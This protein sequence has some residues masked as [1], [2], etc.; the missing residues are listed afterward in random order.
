MRDA[1]QIEEGELIWMIEPDASN[2]DD[3][4]KSMSSLAK[5]WFRA[6]GGGVADTVFANEDFDT[7]LG[8]GIELV[9]RHKRDW[10][11]NGAEEQLANGLSDYTTHVVI[12][13][14]VDAD[15]V[16]EFA[17]V[18]TTQLALHRQP[19]IRD[20]DGTIP[21]LGV[22]SK[23]P[24][25]AS[26][27]FALDEGDPKTGDLPEGME[28]EGNFVRVTES[29]RYPRALG[30]K[31]SEEG[32]DDDLDGPQ[33]VS[34]IP[35]RL[36]VP[37]DKARWFQWARYAR[38]W[39]VDDVND[40]V[41]DPNSPM[42]DD[43]E[44]AVELDWEDGEPISSRLW[45]PERAAARFV[46]A[47]GR[48]TRSWAKPWAVRLGTMPNLHVS[49][50]YPQTVDG[51][52]DYPPMAF[53]VH[54]QS[55]G[56]R[57]L[58]NRT[59]EWEGNAF[60]VGPPLGGGEYLGLTMS[61]DPL[62][63]SDNLPPLSAASPDYRSVS[64]DNPPMR[65]DRRWAEQKAS[66]AP[67][68]ADPSDDAAYWSSRWVV[69]TLVDGERDVRVL[70]TGDPEQ[71][72]NLPYSNILFDADPANDY[73]VA[74][75][76]NDA[77]QFIADFGAGWISTNSSLPTTSGVASEY[78][79]TYA[80]LLRYRHGH[81]YHV[82]WDPDGLGRVDVD[83]DGFYADDNQLESPYSDLNP[84]PYAWA[85]RNTRLPWNW[86]RNADVNGDG[87]V[88]AHQWRIFEGLKPTFFAFSPR[89]RV[90]D[91][92]LSTDPSYDP[93][94][95]ASSPWSYPDKGYYGPE[96]IDGEIVMPHGLQLSM[97]NANF[98][99]VGEALGALTVAHE[100][101]MPLQ[102]QG[103]GGGSFPAA[104]YGWPTSPRL[105][106]DGNNDGIGEF[107]NH[108]SVGSADGIAT[109]RTFSEGLAQR[110]HEGNRIGRL[111]LSGVGRIVDPQL[112][113]A[114][115]YIDDWD[116]DTFDD[117]VCDLMQADHCED[118]GGYW[119]GV[120]TGCQDNG[121]G[122]HDPCELLPAGS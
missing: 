35:S 106:F 76:L 80:N 88:E 89:K 97:K 57:V 114:C 110:L 59:W 65:L 112:R 100:L 48:V 44:L 63:V 49:L 34:A 21:T 95:L 7:R 99:H 20:V 52:S 121:D 60:T 18:V 29:W 86:D 24:M 28:Y 92:I 101:Y 85:T 116:R 50:A 94:D 6:V 84:Y 43:I 32:L 98:E 93:L 38:P 69:N 31:D 66:L 72:Q 4:N 90:G 68:Q 33:G 46:V 104:W 108:P 12:D 13:R 53:P 8:V 22:G 79:D 113:G 51:S 11:Q 27:R 47:D 15:G 55:S 3:S 103:A 14:T 5:D 102:T 36:R 40:G 75:S 39:A 78:A 120:G 30:F 71:D 1:R 45:R 74:P 58:Q 105:P 87:I 54:A 122:N 62:L 119:Y 41:N 118:L 10:N 2:N 37:P 107:P 77:S 96:E 109:L 111:R 42:L 64:L 81:V 16:D 19:D 61:E 25:N 82:D 23:F 26:I 17:H 56:Q 83:G 9:R 115:C 67:T 117:Y 73:P 70:V 91:Q